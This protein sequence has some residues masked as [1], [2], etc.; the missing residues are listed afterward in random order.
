MIN[1]SLDE[2]ESVPYQLSLLNTAHKLSTYT[3]QSASYYSETLYFTLPGVIA[4]G[5]ACC[6]D[7]I[8][9]FEKKKIDQVKFQ[10]YFLL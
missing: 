7:R 9:F 10:T 2:V 3:Y 5:F 4:L 6:S 1:S 8:Q